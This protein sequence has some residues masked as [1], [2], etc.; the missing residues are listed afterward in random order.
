M[1]TLPKPIDTT[2]TLSVLSG[3][4]L[5]ATPSLNQSEFDHA[6]ILICQ[7]DQNGAMGLVINHPIEDM[8][9]DTLLSNLKLETIENTVEDVTVFCGGPVNRNQGF[10]LLSDD[11]EAIGETAPIRLALPQRDQALMDLKISQSTQTLLDYARGNGPSRAR[12]FLGYSGWAPGQLEDEILR[13]AWLLA[14]ARYEWVFDYP[15]N[16]LWSEVLK[17]IGIRP[18]ALNTFSG[19]A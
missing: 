10:V 7:H 3:Q 19:N 4:V 8:G 14:Q 16:H 5:I 9:L 1:E 13:N 11:Y 15:S 12:I 2:V 6:I 18:N 17:S